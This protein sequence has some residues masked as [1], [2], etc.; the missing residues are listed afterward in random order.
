M[1][2]RPTAR[3]RRQQG[4]SFLR[5]R[6][7]RRRLFSNFRPPLSVCRC[8]IF[9]P[10]RSVWH[11]D[12]SARPSDAEESGRGRGKQ[13][14][15]CTYE[16]APFVAASRR[17]AETT[18][19]KSKNSTQKT[20]SLLSLSLSLSFSNTPPPKTAPRRRG[21][22]RRDQRHRSPRKGSSS[23]ASFMFCFSKNTG[24]L[25]LSLSHLLSF[26]FLR[27]LPNDKI[28]LFHVLFFEKHWGPRS[29]SPPLLA[30][31]QRQNRPSPSS[32]PPPTPARSSRAR[33]T[34]ST[35]PSPPTARPPSPTSTRS[36]R[37]RAPPPP[38]SGASRSR[39]CSRTSSS[40]TSRPKSRPSSRA[41]STT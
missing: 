15:R 19:E 29:L 20:F 18:A 17:Q 3:F 13:L 2:S 23:S 21:H 24:A 39:A 4:H 33:P 38:S 37:P 12:R 16:R 31:P 27:L 9:R 28:G 5:R 26:L 11:S 36:R 10:C 40:P 32:R 41:T 14:G 25:S 35:A 7:L 34:S 22:Q 1:K 30:S 8:Q 6:A